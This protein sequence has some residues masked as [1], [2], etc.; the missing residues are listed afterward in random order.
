MFRKAFIAVLS[1]ALIFMTGTAG[2]QDPAAS[3]G[4]A[5][6]LSSGAAASA[7][8]LEEVKDGTFKGITG[9]YEVSAD[10]PAGGTYC[11][12]QGDD[13]EQESIASTGVIPVKPNTTYQLQVHA[14]NNIPLGNVIFGFGQSRAADK[15]KITS[16]VEWGWTQLPCN[17]PE[18][19][20]CVVRFTTFPETRGV[21][22]FFKVSNGGTGKAW[23]DNLVL[24]EV[25]EKTPAVTFQPFPLWASWTDIPTMT[26]KRNPENLNME[27]GEQKAE[28]TPLQLVCNAFVPADAEITLSVSRAGKTVF[29][30]R[31]KASEK[32]EFIL[33]LDSWPAGKYRVRASVSADG[34]ELCFQEKVLWR[35]VSLPEEKPEPVQCVSTLPG[36]VR[37]VNGKPFCMIYYS[38]FPDIH[39]RPDFTEY[40][41]MENLLRISKQ[42]LGVN[43]LS[44]ISYGPAPSLKLPREEYLPKAVEYYSE[45]YRKQLDFCREH[46]MY[47]S[48]SLHMGS[49]LSPRGKIDCELIREVVRRIKDHPALL[50]YG[51]DEPDVRKITPEE[52][53]EM[54]HAVKS[55]DTAHP[56]T[57]NLCNKTFF[58]QFVPG[59]DV[60]SFDNYPY[61]HSD[62]RS[63][64]QFSKELLAAKPDVPFNVYLQT[65]QYSYAAVPTNEFIY[66]EFIL[67]LIDGSRSLLFYSWNE[68]AKSGGHCLIMYPEMQAAV[69]LAAE[70]GKRLTEQ[71]FTAQPVPVELDASP[72]IAYQLYRSKDHDLLL[73]VNMSR[74]DDAAI[75]L[76]F[77]DK[78]QLSDA[79]DPAWTWKPGEKVV[80]KPYQTLIVSVR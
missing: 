38:H 25:N 35:Q 62:L 15:F 79:L 73:A 63:W 76:D 57:V 18:W 24:T 19:K 60:A 54:Y 12:V 42:Q 41:D 13:S 77:P 1:A 80:L 70:H 65:F 27:W 2:E 30:Q 36:R 29:E 74:S 32:L 22:I 61:P 44:V 66:A 7:D 9:K 23:W 37:A 11:M 45:Q 56:V 48:A 59:T 28:E 5:V 31:R 8:M 16:H 14:R 40:P 3:D 50:G 58:R 75:R 21:R 51:Y 71:L 6:Q 34:R 43:V 20:P 4:N 10:H 68:R 47:G 46:G 53:L 52:I 69:R 64:R 55:E 39:I 78:K 67:S 49:S 26:G 17:M 33:P 72:D